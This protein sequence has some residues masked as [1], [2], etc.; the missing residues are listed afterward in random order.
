MSKSFTVF[1]YLYSLEFAS[2]PLYSEI[3]RILK[4]HDESSFDTLGPLI[5]ILYYMFFQKEHYK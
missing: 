3:N 1:L 4:T 2:P 5:C